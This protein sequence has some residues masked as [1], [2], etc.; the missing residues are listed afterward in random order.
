MVCLLDFVLFFGHTNSDATPW[1]CTDV[2]ECET[3]NPCVQT[4]VNT[5]GS[6]ICRC[7]PGY[8]LEEDGIHCSGNGLG[9]VAV[10]LFRDPGPGQG[11]ITGVS[12]GFLVVC[13]A[14]DV[15]QCHGILTTQNKD[16]SLPETWSS[17][18]P[19]WSS[20]FKEKPVSRSGMELV[21]GSTCP[22][23]QVDLRVICSSS[24]LAQNLKM[25]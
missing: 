24:A 18:S 14:G 20:D 15:S 8:E 6:F 7:D 3:E 16:E 13:L 25:V 23:L 17:F 10:H 12:S 22:V 19:S 2:N 1:F 21:R 4:C 5:Y 9:S 11:I